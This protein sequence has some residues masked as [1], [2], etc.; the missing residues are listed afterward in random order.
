MPVES[1]DAKT[2]TEF[3]EGSKIYT[4]QSRIY[5]KLPYEHESVNH[6]DGEYVREGGG[7]N[8]M[9]SVWAVLKRSLHGT[10]HHV[11][12]KHLHRY[13]NEATMR[14][15]DGNVRHDRISR[16]ES[17]ARGMDNRRIRYRNLIVAQMVVAMAA[18]ALERMHVSGLQGL[19]RLVFNGPLVTCN[20]VKGNVT[21]QDS[22]GMGGS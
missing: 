2:A 1:A 13:V 4:D 14:L 16:M 18:D 12:R 15:N 17:L 21:G 11:S 9:E 8:G 22:G 3:A 5:D 20:R 7:T 19:E 10:W 6:S